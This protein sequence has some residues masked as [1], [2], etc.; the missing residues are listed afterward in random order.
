MLQ[1]A[2]PNKPF[3]YLDKVLIKTFVS[4]H[5]LKKQLAAA[6]IAVNSSGWDL[7]KPS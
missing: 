3:D 6:S 1:P 4:Y 5:K 7:L 2:Q